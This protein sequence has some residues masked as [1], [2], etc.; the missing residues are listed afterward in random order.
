MVA[1]HVGE[2]GD[3]GKYVT[4]HGKMTLQLSG[5]QVFYT[6][7]PQVA[8][9]LKSRVTSNTARQNGLSENPQEWSKNFT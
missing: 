6:A 7:P 1:S 4:S 5:K 8:C 3:F 2:Y 9:S